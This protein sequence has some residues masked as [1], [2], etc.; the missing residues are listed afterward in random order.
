MRGYGKNL[1]RLPP[2]SLFKDSSMA[3][4]PEI[5]TARFLT[6]VRDAPEVP[7]PIGG[8]RILIDFNLFH[9]HRT[10]AK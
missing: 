1:T 7:Y 2:V 10:A 9:R 6:T 4:I 5:L 3:R 8:G